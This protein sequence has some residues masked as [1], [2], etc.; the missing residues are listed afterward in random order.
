MTHVHKSVRTAGTDVVTA[1]QIRIP[2]IHPT[3]TDGGAKKCCMCC[4]KALL[5]DC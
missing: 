3:L 2:A 5:T 4:G 1:D